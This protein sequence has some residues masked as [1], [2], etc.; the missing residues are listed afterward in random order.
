MFSWFSKK[1]I[2]EE[3]AKAFWV[4]FE[5][6]EAWII[7]CISKSDAAFVWAIDKKLKAV[8]PYFKDE[9]EFQLGFNNNAGEFYFF[10]LGNKELIR[11]A[12]T[13]DAM[14]PAVLAEKWQFI[15][16]E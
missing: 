16:E 11:D 9:L 4:W 15:I 3:A 2:N 7:D 6:Q 14:M 1:T 13:L 5:E 10:H 12:Q 8:F